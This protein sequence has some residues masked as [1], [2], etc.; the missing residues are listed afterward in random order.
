MNDE[1]TKQIKACEPCKVWEKGRCCLP[2]YQ[3]SDNLN[4]PFLMAYVEKNRVCIENFPVMGTT[5][6]IGFNSTI[7]VGIQ[8]K[9]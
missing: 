1:S 4:C 3:K 9:K 7:T 6:K 2:L 5:G 8:Y